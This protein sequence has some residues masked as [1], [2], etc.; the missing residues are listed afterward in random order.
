M[1][2]TGILLAALAAVV[3]CYCSVYVWGLV[4]HPAIGAES[5]QIVAAA[6]HS[7]EV[8]AAA[9]RF[10]P[11]WPAS[12]LGEGQKTELRSRIE[13]DLA[14][15]FAGQALEG[16]RAA[17]LGWL[18]PA[19]QGNA[20]RNLDFRIDYFDA[21]VVWVQGD[22]AT[23]SATYRLEEKNAQISADLTRDQVFCGWLVARRVFHMQRID[24][25]WMV[26]REE[27]AGDSDDSDEPCEVFGTGQAPG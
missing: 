9:P 26:V 3:A 8:A 21:G 6:K 22:G 18:E 5:G 24:G 23:L 11:A 16:Q 19:S 14:A 7:V 25:A 15:A 17:L 13:R 27:V 10:D 1:R 2:K 4:P 12:G 20:P